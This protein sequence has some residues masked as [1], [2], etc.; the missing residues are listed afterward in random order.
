MH[1]AAHAVTV[2]IGQIERLGQD[3]LSSECRVTMDEQRQI[4]LAAFLSRSVLL[5]AGT[6]HGHR[7]HCL[8]MAG[9][10]NQVDMNFLTRA[11]QVFPSRTHVIFD[12]AAA[13][14]AA[15]VDILKPRKNLFGRALGNLH[16]NVQA[17]AVA[18]AHD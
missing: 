1:R 8:Q 6:A 7:I 5:G 18:H 3:A 2:Q 10:G 12:V 13:Q 15:R 4:F 14:H 17:A 9:I 16:N 11:G